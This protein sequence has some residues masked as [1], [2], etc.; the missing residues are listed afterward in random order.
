MMGELTN[1]LWQSTVFAV[2]AGFLI[3]AFRRSRAQ[4]RYWVW[5]AA[6]VKFL[7]P[8]WLLISLGSRLEMTPS[9]PRDAGHRMRQTVSDTML[10]WSQPFPAV[11]RSAPFAPRRTDWMPLAMFGLWAG[12]IVCVALIRYRGWRRIRAAVRAS[13]TVELPGV[14]AEARSSTALIEPGVV[15]IF[16]PLLLL[17]DGILENLTPG[18][19]DFVIAHELCHARRRDNLTAAIHMVVEAVFWFHPLVWWI[20]ARMVEERERACD[21]EVLRSGGDPQVYA[22]SIVKVCRSYLESPVYCVSGVTGADLKKRMGLILSGWAPGSLS[23]AHKTVLA[24]AGVLAL[25]LPVI[26]GVLDAPV[27]RAQSSN[28]PRFA[29]AFI[30]SCNEAS[31]VPGGRGG[32][33]RSGAGGGPLTSISAPVDSQ[34][35]FL[36]PQLPLSTNFNAGCQT[37]ASL[38]HLAY[39]LFPDGAFNL[40]AFWPDTIPIEGGPA[41]VS[42]A[43]YRIDATAV[44]PATGD[45]LQGPMLQGLLGDRFRLK[46]HRETRN[47]PGYELVVASG[48]L[49]M[50]AFQG[51]C[52]PVHWDQFFAA[53]ARVRFTGRVVEPAFKDFSRYCSS[54]GGGSSTVAVDAD[55]TSIDEFVEIFLHMKGPVVNKTGLKGLFN[56]HLEFVPEQAGA[57]TPPPGPSIFTA[58]EEQLGLKL[59]PATVRE[60]FLVIDSVEK[61]VEN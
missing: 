3:L 44:V 29:V 21:E 56:I 16:R 19:L 53:A 11:P 52:I 61:P 45:M 48:G 18:Q 46:I 55:G 59:Q 43:K 23:V 31:T 13:S 51:T 12:G 36:V 24:A 33:G 50:P 42:S 57:A 39:G 9:T 60:E 22:E 20:G 2:A 35:N 4:V 10:Q 6:S 32:G 41:W 37:V 58:L 17:P 7:V 25:A 34:G 8:F 1:H 5:F 14:R 49:R 26:V 47:V 38:V 54:I 15:G 30:N 27:V 28:A 40:P